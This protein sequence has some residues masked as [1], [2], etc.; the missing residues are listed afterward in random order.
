VHLNKIKD[1]VYYIDAAVNM[2]L[3][4][5]DRREALLVDTGIDES[6]A[7]KVRRLLEENGL[8]LKGI[9]ITHAHADHCGGAPH[10]VKATGARVYATAFE[11]TVLEFPVWEPLYL[12]AGA[13]PPAPLRH[14]FFLAP[15]V[16]V[17]EVIGPGV[18]TV[19]GCEVEVVDLAGHTLGQ[20]GVAARG[21]FFCA[22][23]V[24]AP[25]VIAKHGVPLNASLE[26]ALQT[27]DLLENRP[28]SYF[29]PA[30]GK[31]VDDIRPVVGANR[32]RIN[33][34]L[35]CI[36]A[37]SDR[38]RTVE[39]VLAAVC[40]ACGVNISN[41][42]QYYLMHLTVMAYLGYLLDREKISVFYEGNRQSFYASSTTTAV[43]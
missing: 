13:Y 9:I 10:L 32:D 43:P 26:K 16:R 35:E 1:D 14:K 4:V 11:K 12:F 5:N 21:V 20:V 2:G 24:I 19:E 36:L 23:A 38:P 15:G 6:V 3:I 34:T 7:R 25:E 33:A 22:D 41:M 17:D 27:F 42:G 30:H 18:Q 29:V 28:D 37:L 39:E 31:P 40:D 8:H